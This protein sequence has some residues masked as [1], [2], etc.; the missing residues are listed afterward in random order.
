MD[1]A[2]FHTVTRPKQFLVSVCVHGRT[3]LLV[4]A[5]DADA[6][7]DK[8]GDILDDP[9]FS[10]DVESADCDID[11]VSSVPSVLYLVFDPQN[12]ETT[13]V[14]R[15]TPTCEPRAPTP[16]EETLFAKN[17]WILTPPTT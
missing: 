3:T 1:T 12:P 5:E 9:N 15:L 10:P 11:R 16:Q 2:S 8:A 17:A 13:M 4:E 7:E 14:S 6:A